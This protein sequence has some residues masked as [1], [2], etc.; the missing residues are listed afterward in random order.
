MSIGSVICV[1]YSRFTSDCLSEAVPITRLD[2]TTALPR[3]LSLYI[4]SFLSP[5]DICAAA[6]VSWH[7]RFLAE[8]VNT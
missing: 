3:F 8:Q 4:M 7:W 1:H 5:R 6:Q 2:F